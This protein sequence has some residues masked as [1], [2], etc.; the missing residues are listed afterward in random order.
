MLNL[1]VEFDFIVNIGQSTNS[2]TYKLRTPGISEHAIY[3][4]IVGSLIPEAFFINSKEM[5][6]FQWVTALM[7]SYSRRLSHYI[8]NNSIVGP[9]NVNAIKQIML[10]EIIKDMKNTFDP[11]GAY[12]IPDGTTREAH[13]V[14]HHLGLILEQHCNKV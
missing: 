10:S 6:S 1:V 3:F 13:S 12:I 9:V 11:N 7:T 5:H 8:D 14:V 2:A 4:T